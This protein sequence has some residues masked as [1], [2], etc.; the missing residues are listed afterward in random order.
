MRILLGLSIL[1]TSSFAQAAPV[2]SHTFF[3][4]RPNFQSAMPER[5]SLFRNELIDD[6]GCFGGALEAV[7]YGGNTTEDGI[8]KIAKFFLPPGCT[9]TFLNVKEFNETREQNP[10]NTDDGTLAKNLEARNFNI[11]TVNESFAST[12][13]IRPK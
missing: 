4:E 13:G 11:R 12:I 1:L 9:T 8:L 3:S 6:C 5:V 2:F 7:F 10:A